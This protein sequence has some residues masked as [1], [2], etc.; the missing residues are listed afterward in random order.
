MSQDTHALDP[1]SRP[2]LGSEK[3][4]RLVILLQIK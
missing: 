3:M 2:A 1:S 4:R